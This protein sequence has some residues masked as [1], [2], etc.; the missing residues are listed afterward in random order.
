MSQY[1][2]A[3]DLASVIEREWHDPTFNVDDLVTKADLL[4][5]EEELF[6]YYQP[7]PKPF[8]AND[9]DLDSDGEVD[10]DTL[11]DSQWYAFDAGETEL[12]SD[13]EEEQEEEEEEEVD[14][15]GDAV[16]NNILEQMDGELH[17]ESYGTI[18]PSVRVYHPPRHVRPYGQDCQ[19]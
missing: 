4:S 1:N 15:D 3:G 5:I 11:R 6:A 17:Q 2:E 9:Q 16:L 14:A 7:V 19:A 12:P 18:P 13:E 10:D 8:G